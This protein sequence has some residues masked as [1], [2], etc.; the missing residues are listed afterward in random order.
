[1]SQ[2]IS[3]NKYGAR[4]DGVTDDTRAI[5][6]AMN[7]GK[8]VIYFQPGRYVINGQIKIPATVHRINFMFADLAAGENLK[9]MSDQ[10]AFTIN[11]FS[12][13]PLLME[14]L[15]AFEEYRGEQYFIDHACKRTLVMSDLH[16]QTG[17]AY[18]NSVSG[19]K[20]FIENICCTDQFPPNPN[21]F[22]FKGQNVW[23]RQMNPERAN[24]EVINDSSQLWILGFKTES[25]GIGFLTRN[26]GST[27]ILGGVINIGGETNPFILNDESNTSIVC[28]SNGWSSGQVFKTVVLEK[29]NGQE[30]T[31]QGVELPKRIL[32][33]RVPNTYIE[34]IFIPLY[35]GY[36]K[37]SI[38]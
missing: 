37:H 12:E 32:P 14:D 24:P 19:G 10:G 13:D 11:E 5:Q 29:R 26:G 15:F 9:S 27:E 21:C 33:A 6:R 28:G 38:H 36:Q 30:R 4:G 16:I 18:F 2:W 23:V 8:K 17:A 1:M 34:Q 20:V 35:V 3:V 7:S 25:R 31:I 22:L